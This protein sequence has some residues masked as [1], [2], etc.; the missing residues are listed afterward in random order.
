M[1]QKRPK[2]IAHRGAS[3]EAPE[4]T[5][6]A[7]ELAWKQGADGV[8]VDVRITEEGHLVVIHD[9]DTKRTARNS[10]SIKIA[11]S[12]LAQLRAVDVG[13]KK[14]PN[15]KIP[16]LE[17]VIT[18]LPRGKELFIELKSRDRR[19]IPILLERIGR[20]QPPRGDRPRRSYFIFLRNIYSEWGQTFLSLTPS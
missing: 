2:I 7:I 4:N 8:E 9:A 13:N 12:T 18:S 3:A 10:K 19:V 1:M 17:E 15:Q 20:G 14:Y 6:A 5:L 16:T 11:Q